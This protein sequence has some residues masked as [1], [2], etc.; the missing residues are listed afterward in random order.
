MQS[1]TLHR[2]C[3]RSRCDSSPRHQICCFFAPGLCP[4]IS[5]L[6]FNLSRAI[7][8]P[9]SNKP[10]RRH[11]GP[12]LLLGTG[13]RRLIKPMSSHAIR[14]RMTPKHLPQ[15]EQFV[16][17]AVTCSMM[18]EAL[19]AIRRPSQQRTRLVAVSCMS[20]PRHHAKSHRVDSESNG[21]TFGP[22][23]APA[24]FHSTLR[25]THFLSRSHH[26]RQVAHSSAQTLWRG[27]VPRLRLR[28]PAQ[29]W[30]VSWSSQ[31]RRC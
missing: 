1:R 2:R 11:R 27:R 10:E 28:A 23:P 16:A 3:G 18:G 26:R 4:S 20:G 29:A 21:Q 6:R 15:L 31:P 8:G 30:R 19:K 13:G 14:A 5:T 12:P 25:L 22:L 7:L 24:L 17:A 9:S